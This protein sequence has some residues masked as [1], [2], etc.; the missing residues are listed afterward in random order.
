MKGKP[1]ITWIGRLLTVI[2]IVYVSVVIYDYSQDLNLWAFIQEHY[3][4]YLLLI[5]AYF[6]GNLLLALAWRF[7]LDFLGSKLSVSVTMW[8]YGTSQ[9]SKYLP[10]NIAH[11]ANRQIIGNELGIKQSIL[12]KSTLWE[13]LT[14]VAVASSFGVLLTNQY[15]A[16]TSFNSLWL[17]GVFWLLVCVLTYFSNY[18]A[19]LKIPLLYLLFFA[20]S[21]GIFSLIFASSLDVQSY[22]FPQYWQLSG[23]F[24]LAW[25]VGFLAP[26]APAGI[27]VREVTLIVLAGEIANAEALI[28]AVVLARSIT[29]FG[30]LFFFFYSQRFNPKRLAL[31]S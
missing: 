12:M 17:F 13:T 6:I 25:L 2:S 22:G 7:I 4:T 29:V 3:L 23:Y 19:L 28:A 24:V 18:R 11:L 16:L 31:R 21:G 5:V 10:G 26:G 20:I 1:V 9:I 14:M 8:F 15:L 27:G 30:D